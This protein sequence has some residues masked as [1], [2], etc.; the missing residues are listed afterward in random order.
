[1]RREHLKRLR[2]ALKVLGDDMDIDPNLF[3]WFVG[4]VE[5]VVEQVQDIAKMKGGE[6]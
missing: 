1:M 3:W 2:D 5:A 6:S 4:E